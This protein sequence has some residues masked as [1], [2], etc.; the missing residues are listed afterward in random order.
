MNPVSRNLLFNLLVSDKIS[1]ISFLSLCGMNLISH[2]GTSMCS[3]YW[4]SSKLQG[5]TNHN[6]KDCITAYMTPERRNSGAG[7][8]VRCEAM[9]R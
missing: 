8:D 9:V 3:I 6:M 1:C 2:K 7:R 4:L 5:V